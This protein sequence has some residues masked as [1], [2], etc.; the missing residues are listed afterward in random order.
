[1]GWDKV[2]NGLESSSLGVLVDIQ[3]V[4]RETAKDSR[5]HLLLGNG[6]SIARF[7]GF[8]YDSLWQ[9][10]WPQLSPQDQ[11]DLQHLQSGSV[12]EALR[13]VQGQERYATLQEHLIKAISQVHP[14]GAHRLSKEDRE[15]A[16]RFLEKFDDI[17]TTNYDL[18]L[19]WIYVH[20]VNEL[21]WN[22]R[23]RDGFFSPDGGPLVFDQKLSNGRRGVFFVHGA[24]HLFAHGGTAGKNKW[25][26]QT[27]VQQLRDNLARRRLPLVVTEGTPEQKLAKI[28][29]NDYLA[30]CWRRL[31][32]ITGTVFAFGFGFN[33]IDDHI[34]Q[35]LATNP[36]LTRLCIGV[37]PGKVGDPIPPRFSEAV[38]RIQALRRD[39]N[40]PRLMTTFYASSTAIIWDTQSQSAVAANP[41]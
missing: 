13:A 20:G 34:L 33:D 11:T 19:Y 37:Y 9:K 39:A 28:Q 24:F 16:A 18:L 1:M 15:G 23:W 32:I 38:D 36:G 40:M 21:D 31:R 5:R 25:E 22:Q 4:L 30:C 2:F 35:H 8:N 14:E 26:G 7:P 10:I 27:L 17:F 6:F 3:Q 12:E 29:A 41:G